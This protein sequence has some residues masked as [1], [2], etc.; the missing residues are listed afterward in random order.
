M[1]QMNR[2]PG[3]NTVGYQRH[4]AAEALIGFG[5][6]AVEPISCVQTQVFD[7][8]GEMSGLKT[9]MQLLKQAKLLPADDDTL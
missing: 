3:N 4:Q 8:T 6:E 9:I 7:N 2:Q 5:N 1:A